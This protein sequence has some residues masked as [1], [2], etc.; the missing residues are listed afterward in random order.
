MNSEKTP[1]TLPFTGELWGIFL[2]F[3]REKKLQDIDSP[4]IRFMR[5]QGPVSI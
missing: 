1:H 2:K 3:Y 4:R 5:H